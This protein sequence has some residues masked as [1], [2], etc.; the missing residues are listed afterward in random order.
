MV[1]VERKNGERLTPLLMPTQNHLIGQ[2][3][4]Q[5]LHFEYFRD[6]PSNS[7]IILWMIYRSFPN[8]LSSWSAALTKVTLKQPKVQVGR[9]Y[10]ASLEEEYCKMMNKANQALGV[11]GKLVTV[12]TGNDGWTLA[13]EWFWEAEKGGKL[14]NVQEK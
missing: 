10:P 6:P 1:A 8:Y 14:L 4:L 9:A 13:D 2:R 5:T 7:F 11:K 3:T 12:N